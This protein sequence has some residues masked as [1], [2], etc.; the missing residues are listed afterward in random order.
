MLSL[1]KIPFSPGKMVQPERM[2]VSPKQE[3]DVLSRPVDRA[4]ARAG[5]QGRGSPELQDRRCF[6]AVADDSMV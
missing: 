6:R 1:L 2:L 3:K 5:R 4:L